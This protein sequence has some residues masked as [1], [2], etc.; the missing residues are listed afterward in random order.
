MMQGISHATHAQCP[1]MPMPKKVFYFCEI[2]EKKDID[3]DLPMELDSGRFSAA[4]AA[5]A[6][7][8]A[9]LDYYG[10]KFSGGTCNPGSEK[11]LLRLNPQLKN[12]CPTVCPTF[13]DNRCRHTLVRLVFQFL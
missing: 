7:W 3:D 8:E 12:R 5:A 13:G 4:A 10:A 6:P 2:V 11:G 9:L 1:C